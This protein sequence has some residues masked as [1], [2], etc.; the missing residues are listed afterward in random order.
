MRIELLKTESEWVQTSLGCYISVNNS[1]LDVI[2]PLN[3][4]HE[5]TNIEIPN[6]GILR[7][8]IRDMGRSDGYLGS[9]SIPIS[10]IT[11]CSSPLMLPLFDNPNS[12]SLSQI[13][14]YRQ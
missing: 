1:L 7:V 2:T 3:N 11:P 5:L 10:L 9:V 13:M 14:S 8:V 12:D 6:Q 4:P